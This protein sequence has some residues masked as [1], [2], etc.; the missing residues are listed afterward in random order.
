[1]LCTVS[2]PYPWV[3]HLRI[4]PTADGNPPMWRADY[5]NCSMP[6]YTARDL[7]IHSCCYP[8]AFL[9]PIPH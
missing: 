3:S 4:Q 6:F 8:Q 7:N 2:P 5:I 9:E 1:M